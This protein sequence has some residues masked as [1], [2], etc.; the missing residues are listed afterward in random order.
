MSSKGKRF[1]HR[2]YKKVS[3]IIYG[4]LSYYKSDPSKS[5]VKY[6]LLTPIKTCAFADAVSIIQLH[7]AI[8]YEAD[9]RRL[10]IQDV[11]PIAIV[12]DGYMR[13]AGMHGEVI[14]W[15]KKRR[16]IG[17]PTFSIPTDM[18]LI[19]T[20]NKIQDELNRYFATPQSLFDE[21][22]PES[23][24]IKGMLGRI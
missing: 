23:K 12:E 15:H 5:R 21:G 22:I 7:P 8:D 10:G 2:W 20:D 3:G 11:Y 4:L 17:T 6:R 14:C 1:W 16:C 13:L 18:T 19:S 24:T 9:I